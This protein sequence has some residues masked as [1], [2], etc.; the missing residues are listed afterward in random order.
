MKKYIHDF[1][2][3]QNQRLSSHYFVLN[4]ECP[5]LL[6][7]ILPGQFAEVRID[8]SPSTY[9]RRPF[10]IY[11]V[12]YEKHT[13][14]ILIK[15]VGAGTEALY[16]MEE[17]DNL[18][19]IYPLGNSFSLLD[20]KKILL[21]GGGVGIAPMFILS[22]FQHSRGCKIDVLIGGRTKEDIIEPEVYSP[23]AKVFV[24]T[25]D[26]SM[27]EKGMVTQHSLFAN[28]LA[29]YSMVYTCGPELMMK[30]VA[31][32]AYS[33]GISCEVSLENLMACGIGACLCCIVETTDGNKTSCVEGPVFNSLNLAGWK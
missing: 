29:G 28:K 31:S 17:G 7:E 15:S 18:N 5:D 24:T 8:N 23:Y 16:N 3:L 9:L 11:D 13:L 32:L 19:M 22:K 25:D 1:R 6:P 26:G 30:A 27:G 10:S 4:L 20:G 14:K 2:V 21:I 12:D 33:Q